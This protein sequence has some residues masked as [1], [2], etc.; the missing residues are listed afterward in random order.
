M[1]KGKS[2]KGSQNKENLV[3]NHKWCSQGEGMNFG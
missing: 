2:S 1:R 3:V